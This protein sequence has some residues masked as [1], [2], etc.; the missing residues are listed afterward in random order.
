[1]IA[2]EDLST[3]P[4]KNVYTDSLLLEDQVLKLVGGDSLKFVFTLTLFL[5]PSLTFQV[6]SGDPFKCCGLTF[7]RLFME[8]H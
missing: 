1:M 2:E 5:S 8:R 3:T 7:W 4:L 6:L